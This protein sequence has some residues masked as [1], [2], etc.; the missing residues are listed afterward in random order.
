MCP[1]A[2][3][4]TA[5][6][7][8]GGAAAALG[9]DGVDGMG[10]R[11]DGVSPHSG[12]APKLSGASACAGRGRGPT[13]ANAR[14]DVLDAK[15][16]SYIDLSYNDKAGGD[17]STAV[18]HWV[19]FCGVMAVDGMWARPL[20]ANASR[21]EALAEEFLVMQ[22]A[23]FIVEER[24]CSP[25]TAEK[26]VS[27]VQGWHARRFGCKLA[28]G[29][30]MWRLKALL[31]GMEAA[32]GGKRPKKKRLGVKPR[33]LA[34]AMARCLGGLSALEANWR[35]ALETG[36][37]GLLRGAELGTATG[38]SWVPATGMTREDVSFRWRGGREE[39]VLNVR[40]RKKGVRTVQGK[41]VEVLLVGGGRFLDPVKALRRLFAEDP[42]PRER[43]ATTPLFRDEVG[44][45][46]TTA[47]V[48][49]VVKW[50]VEMEG[51]DSRL[52]GAHSLRIGGATAALAAGV[53]ALVIKAMGRWGS[54]IYEVYAQLSDAAARS[55]GSKVA[56]VDYD[57]VEGA[58]YSEEL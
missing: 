53:P 14:W 13:A 3:R 34:T 19:R 30:R 10:G 4:R 9:D 15:I 36:F 49:G 58:Y 26:Y 29:M 23:C 44:A 35:A 54:D 31:K 46:V 21:E 48:R 47:K 57:Y 51:G 39:A 1:G 52:Y 28:G 11:G 20:A 40:P 12:R 32:Q 50:L 18:Q 27:T 37:C 55:F 43:W 7:R 38:E 24:G 8:S 5:A 56:N 6:A 22:Y 41:S 2:R 45:A 16:K 17:R 42:V 33:Q 25:A